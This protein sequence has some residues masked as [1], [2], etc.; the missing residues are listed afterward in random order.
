MNNRIL[1]DGELR[2][3]YNLNFVKSAKKVEVYIVL[4]YQS[5]DGNSS[6]DDECNMNAINVSEDIS[7]DNPST[8][9]EMILCR[10][11]ESILQYVKD[12]LRKMLS[13]VDIKSDIDSY[14]IKYVTRSNIS[15]DGDKCVIRTTGE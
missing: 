2:M 10:I 12:N 3:S 5:Y 4:N 14:S 9:E 13:K 11:D 7:L 6:I 15:Y 1:K 8:L